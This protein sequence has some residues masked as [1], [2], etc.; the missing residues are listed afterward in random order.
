MLGKFVY[1]PNTHHNTLQ[2]LLVWEEY[3]RK[4]RIWEQ[5]FLG[6]M[7]RNVKERKRFMEK[8]LT[9][10]RNF[11]KIKLRNRLNSEGEG[12]WETKILLL[13]MWQKR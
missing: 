7:H 8:G 2:R 9:Y 13:L 3:N 11:R 4:T 5:N 6:N 10:Y 1:T 12:Q